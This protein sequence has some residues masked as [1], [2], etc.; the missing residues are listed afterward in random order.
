M[1]NKTTT[2]PKIVHTKLQDL[3]FND[4]KQL[5]DDNP[6]ILFKNQTLTYQDLE[7]N[8]YK[9]GEPFYEHFLKNLYYDESLYDDKFK[10]I[11]PISSSGI[12]GD[13]YLEWHKDNIF[14]EEST[15]RLL[16]AVS[17]PDN[18]SG[19]TYWA[20]TVKIYNQLPEKIKNDLSNV[21]VLY[22]FNANNKSHIEKEIWKTA[23]VT[24]NNQISLNLSAW[25]SY[26][27]IVKLKN[28]D[29]EYF[30]TI[31][32][33][34]E[35]KFLNNNDFVY[36]HKWNEN[37]L[38]FFNNLTTIHKREKIKATDKERLLYRLTVKWNEISK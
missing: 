6:L 27:P 13:N 37:D 29:Y 22:D 12:L 31:V 9:F 1:E 4:V 16:Y 5:I 7:D 21:E 17:I 33:Y 11:V 35:D 10:Y 30:K 2:Y 8:C 32:T 34:I 19:T 28:I 18:D 14:M 24:V 26:T 36:K 25:M 23:L 3:T 15:G 38:I 20:D